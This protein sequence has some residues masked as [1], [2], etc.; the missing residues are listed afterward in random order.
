MNTVVSP[1][2]RPEVYHQN[3]SKGAG[4]VLLPGLTPLLAG[5]TAH[6]HAE[7]HIDTY[8][9]K[10]RSIFG[11]QDGLPL[12]R[13]MCGIWPLLHNTCWSLIL[14]TADTRNNSYCYSI[15][16]TYSDPK[17]SRVSECDST[18]YISACS[19]GPWEAALLEFRLEHLGGLS[20][21]ETTSSSLRLHFWIS[22]CWYL[23]ITI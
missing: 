2:E 8:N 4:K 5:K 1:R 16:T 6:V 19:I 3:T 14:S 13:N 23:P 20:D 7:S 10:P 12:F 18:N 17:F 11:R 15:H 9:R 22:S 21:G